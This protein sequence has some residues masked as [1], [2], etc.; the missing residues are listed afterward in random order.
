[1]GDVKSHRDLIVY[2]KAMDLAVLVYKHCKQFP[3]SE[4]YGLAQQLTRAA[5]SVPGNIAE[6][7]GRGA[8]KDYA[9]FLGIAKGSL[10][11]TETYLKLAV[12]LGYL[13]EEDVSETLALIIEISKILTA[14]R[15]K[16]SV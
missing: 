15:S 10:L 9:R 13:A 3:T 11:E 6:G 8:V 12:R 16:L 7:N 14:M 1:M 4:T 5:V 2:N